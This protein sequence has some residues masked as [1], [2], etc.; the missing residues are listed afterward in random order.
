MNSVS[1]LMISF[2]SLVC[3]D[4]CPVYGNYFCPEGT[5]TERVPF[6]TIYERMQ[7]TTVNT[8]FIDSLD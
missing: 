1:A 6:I 3:A 8:G 7:N 5:R 2:A 4:T